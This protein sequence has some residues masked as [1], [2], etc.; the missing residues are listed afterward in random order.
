MP[1]SAEFT[2]LCQSQ[3][4]V[5]AQVVGAN[6]TAV[7][8]AE[9]WTEQAFPKLIP[10]AVYPPLSGTAPPESPPLMPHRALPVP[11][12][13]T[14]EARPVQS[15]E[16]SILTPDE[17]KAV[18]Q[19][20]Y[21]LLLPGQGAQADQGASQQLVIPLMHEGGVVGVLIGWKV[22]HP[23]QP[24]E[25]H[26]MEEC[27]HALAL[28]CVLDQRGQWSQRQLSAL[29][30]L[31]AQQ[32]DR[33]HELLH[34]LRNPLTAIKT[35]GKLLAKR[36]QPEDKNQPLVLNML[37]EGDRMQHILGYFDDTLQ[38]AD[39]SRTE[40]SNTAASLT[41]F[42]QNNPV[43]ETQ[44]LPVSSDSLAHFG[45]ALAIE[46]CSLTWLMMPLVNSTQTLAETSNRLFHVLYVEDDTTVETD[47][48]AFIEIV[49]NF[50]ENAFK[51]SRP[52]D[53]IWVQWGCHQ[54]CYPTYA[55]ILV[56]DTGPGISKDDQSHIFE[57][58]Y[59]SQQTSETTVGHGLGLAIARDLAQEMEGFIEVYSP[60]SEIPWPLP[61]VLQ[62]LSWDAGTAFMLWLPKTSVSVV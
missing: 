8:L 10:V 56:G 29:N 23:W 52:G 15:L 19:P 13:S 9:G 4:A 59:R 26:Q 51:Y 7:Y 37:R 34:Q 45:G 48:N 21:S 55:G 39:D 3:I 57:R 40:T 17:A 62:E 16:S 36:I 22:D 27:A 38:A 14:V 60:L 61:D 2:A 1:A 24:E 53:H 25:R 43:V 49:S 42:D 18:L 50:L 35:F 11:S 46:P 58:H 12:S 54:H 31:Q 6:S 47:A 20:E 5:M 30:R 28:A 41:A 44:A 33:F 32:S